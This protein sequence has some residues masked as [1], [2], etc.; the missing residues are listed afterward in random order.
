M[1][2][3]LEKPILETNIELVHNTTV[4]IKYC[5]SFLDILSNKLKPIEID[6]VN[7]DNNITTP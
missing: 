3:K 1:E 5:L 7:I 2:I 6:D 4:N